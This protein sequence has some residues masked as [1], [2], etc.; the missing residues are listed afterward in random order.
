MNDIPAAKSPIEHHREVLAIAQHQLAL[1]CARSLCEPYDEKW[2]DVIGRLRNWVQRLE[3]EEER[4][5]GI[6]RFVH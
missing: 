3:N 1:A 4:F 5:S 2:P 6:A